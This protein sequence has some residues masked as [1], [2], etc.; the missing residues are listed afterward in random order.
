MFLVMG[1]AGLLSVWVRGWLTIFLVPLS[2]LVPVGPVGMPS[3]WRLPLMRSFWC[4]MGSRWM[5]LWRFW[6]MGGLRPC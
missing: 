6:L 5:P 4:L 2:S 3:E 1:L